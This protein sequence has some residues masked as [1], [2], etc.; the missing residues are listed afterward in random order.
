MAALPKRGLLPGEWITV[1]LGSGI[2]TAAGGKFP[3]DF[4]GFR[5]AA[6]EPT[7]KRLPGPTLAAGGSVA[8][9]RVA[10]FDLD[11]KPD[12]A[13]VVSGESTVR[14]AQ[15]TGG[16]NFTAAA[17]VDLGKPVLALEVAD[18]D[19]DGHIDIIAGAVDRAAIFA[20][21]ATGISFGD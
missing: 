10:D 5:V 19:G 8:I 12:L 17:V 21:G 16:G 4:F 3:G 18:A 11:G 9:L 1:T 2:A 14:I 15:G 7:G 20:G 13:Y 6:L